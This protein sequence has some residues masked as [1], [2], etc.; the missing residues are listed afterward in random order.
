MAACNAER[1]G[2]AGAKGEGCTAIYVCRSVKKPSQKARS[3]FLVS[4][5][6]GKPSTAARISSGLFQNTNTSFAGA[7]PNQLSG[8]VP[9]P[10]DRRDQSSLGGRG[11]NTAVP[12]STEDGGRLRFFSLGCN[13][14]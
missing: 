2:A 8:P 5:F 9:L 10:H 1:R 14:C 12:L 13:E 3:G 4:Q 7:L 6:P 11:G